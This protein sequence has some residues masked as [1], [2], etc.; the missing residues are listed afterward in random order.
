M[1][2]IIGQIQG[3]NTI[4]VGALLAAPKYCAPIRFPGYDEMISKGKTFGAQQAAPLPKPSLIF[5]LKIRT[6]AEML[7]REI[8]IRSCLCPN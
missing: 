8:S 7:W 1:E 5:R 6:M 4:N 2:G 3:L